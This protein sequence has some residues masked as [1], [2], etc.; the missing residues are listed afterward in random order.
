MIGQLSKNFHYKIENTTHSDCHL[1]AGLY[2]NEF[3]IFNDQQYVCTPSY[4]IF[5][6]LL[7]YCGCSINFIVS[8]D[9]FSGF[10]SANGSSWSGILRLIDENKIDFIP[11]MI[12]RND[13]R[14]AILD[15]G[16]LIP[17]EHT[18]AILSQKRYQPDNDPSKL[19][20][21][22]STNVWLLILIS[23]VCFTISLY[24]MNKIQQHY[25]DLF[26]N[27][28]HRIQ[29]FLLLHNIVDIFALF[30]GQGLCNLKKFYAN[31]PHRGF[32]LAAM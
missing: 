9:N 20:R 29:E 10:L 17:Q 6:I 23:F 4:E 31:Y 28:H 22:F 32:T 30:M 7:N 8:D 1:R 14:D 13:E 12:S 21:A 27:K 3:F 24:V 5:S 18:V 16:F 11:H 25:Y 26:N 2:P 15:T 19:F